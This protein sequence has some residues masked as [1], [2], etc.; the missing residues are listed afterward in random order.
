MFERANPARNRFD[1]EPFPLYPESL[2]FWT[3]RSA[4]RLLAFSKTRRSACPVR[5]L[6]DRWRAMVL[7]LSLLAIAGFYGFAL[8]RFAYSSRAIVEQ[9]SAEFVR[10]YYPRVGR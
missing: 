7:A 1:S 10:G 6:A 9:T 4:D 5:M 8:Q 2:H 3:G